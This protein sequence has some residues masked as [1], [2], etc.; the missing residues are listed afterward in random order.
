MTK[1]LTNFT[2][3]R[4]S[5]GKKTLVAYMTAG[6]PGWIDAIH[7]CQENGAD[8]IEIGL[9]FSDPIMDG[10]V[11]AQASAI[12]LKNGAKTLKLLEEIQNA[13]FI[14]PVAVMTYT[15]VLYSHGVQEIIP[16]L[17][18]AKI[19]GLILP[20]LTF[21]QSELFSNVLDGTDISLIQLVSSTT[22]EVRKKQILEAT[23]GFLYC[24]A[25][26]GITGQNVDLASSYTN[27]IEPIRN[28]CPVPTYCGV[29]IRTPEDAAALSSLADGV[30][31]GTS[32]VEKMIN[33]PDGPTNVGILIK[34]M[35]D[36]IDA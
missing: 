30:I 17:Q 2:I 16:I 34:Q 28:Q 6:L 33:Q 4:K 8:I 21:E 7:A 11:I 31:V 9:P 32:L 10:P 13:N 14:E 22:D 26:K 1:S 35:R 3:K 18:A 24:V 20:D 27:F 19:S 15:N 25:I 36:S 23:Q 29:G 5:E 12:A